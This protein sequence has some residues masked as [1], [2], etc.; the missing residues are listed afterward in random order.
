MIHCCRLI[1]FSLL[2]MCLQGPSWAQ[3]STSFSISEI[4]IPF[5]NAYSLEDH[6]TSRT[7]Y[8]TKQAANGTMY[9]ANGWGPGV[10]EGKTGRLLIDDYLTRPLNASEFSARIRN[11][12]DNRIKIIKEIDKADAG[13]SLADLAR[14]YELVELEVDVLKLR[15]K[16]Y[17]NPQIAEALFISRNTVKFHLKNLFSKMGIETRK[18]ATESVES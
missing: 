17:T 3:E 12:P 18:G 1:C 7:T 15:A 14:Q 13:D 10:F 16:R 8:N 9:F 5:V 4:G 6:F 11:I 2:L